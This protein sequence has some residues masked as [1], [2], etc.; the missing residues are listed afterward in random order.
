[1][2]VL[3]KNN[4]TATLAAGISDTATTIVVSSGQGTRFPTLS[5]SNYFYA[6]LYDSSN[7]IE[8]V[9]VTARTTD[10]LTVVR[11]Y[12][13]STAHS[14]VTG[15]SIAMRLT[16]GALAD[17]TAYT[18]SG[19]ISAT[20]L[21][22]AVNELDS[23]K[24]GLALDNT[25][26][27]NNI[28]NNSVTLSGGATGNLT[29]DVTGDVTGNVTGNLTGNAS[30]ATSFTG[31]A[32]VPSGGT[33]QTSLTLN[34]LAVGNGQFAVKGVAPGAAGTVLG[35]TIYGTAV[36]TGSIAAGTLTV[37]AITSGTLTEGA[38]IQGIGITVGTTIAQ[39]TSSASAVASPTFSSGGASGQATM[40]LSS[41][42]GLVSGQLVTGTGIPSNTFLLYV[43]GTTVTLTRNLT[44]QA[45][46]TYSFYT[47]G[48][49][50]TYTTTPS[51]TVSSTT[52]NAS[53]G[54]SFTNIVPA[55]YITG[56]VFT[57]G[58]T[59]T[60]PAGVTGLKAI[61]VGGGGGAGGA[62]GSGCCGYAGGGGG[63]GANATKYFNSLTPGQ[64][65][66]IAVG[67]GG[68]GGGGGYYSSG[69][70]GGNSSVSGTTAVFT[71]S[72]SGTALTVSNLTSGTIGIG[73]TISGTSVTAATTITA[74]NGLNWTVSASQTV[75]STTITSTISATGG[76]G[77]GGVSASGGGGAGSTGS[78]TNAS[79]Q[80]AFGTSPV[81]GANGQGAAS[82]AGAAGIQ[83]CV[84]LEW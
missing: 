15:D 69:G 82:G 42:S 34:N 14:Y 33:G 52:I 20:T 54:T 67:S 30:T 5:G 41:V 45:A 63:Y 22:G 23:E 11:G 16:A 12:D 32:Q 81:Y 29:G 31:L 49:L 8:I 26:T 62:G 83:G 74:G 3:F 43:N 77:G 66:S 61:M 46:G 60:I 80:G 18:P 24:A 84:L 71:G 25:F 58:G 19:N 55:A 48:G 36:V 21:A 39:L 79:F 51:Q 57:S 35:S 78:V 2:T 28:F 27:G 40:V 38:T 9:K 59:F 73:Q 75:S 64:T 37:T 17:V 76:G 44:T 68:S 70:A 50:G 72:I 10:T 56:Q 47:P 6:T 7:N 53:N 65:L 1:M 4:V 13:N